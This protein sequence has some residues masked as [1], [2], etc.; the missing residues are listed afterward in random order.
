MAFKLS[1]LF[2]GGKYR[3]AIIFHVAGR[4]K[5]HIEKQIDP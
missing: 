1:Y 5:L 2:W 3:D 4:L